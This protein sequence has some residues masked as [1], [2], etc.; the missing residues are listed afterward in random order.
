M[1]TDRLNVLLVVVDSLRYDSANEFASNL[2]ELADENVSFERAIA[3]ASWSLPSHASL[4]T[5]EYPYEHGVCRLHDQMRDVPLVERLRHDGYTAYGVSANGFAGPRMTID[6]SFDEFR[7]TGGDEPFTDGLDV[8][9]L[10]YR[11]VE[12]DVSKLQLAKSLL[13]SSLV[14]ENTPRSIVNLTTA[15]AGRAAANVPQLQRVPH[16]VFTPRKGYSYTPERNTGSIRSFVDEREP[17]FFVF[18]NYM[19][20]HTPYT[21]PQRHLE[22]VTDETVS[23]SERIRLN[24]EVALPWAFVERLEEGTLE[25]AD[26]ERV[27][28]LYEAEV[29]SVDE[30]IG[31]LVELLERRG[32]FEE[33]LVV[34]T[35][36]HGQNLGEEDELGRRRMGHEASASD[37]LLHVPLVVANPHLDDRTIS[38]PVSIRRLYDL[39]LGAADGDVTTESVVES[40]ATDRPVLSQYPALG[41]ES[42]YEAHPDVPKELADQ[43]VVHDTTVAYEDDWKVGVCSD[44]TEWA[45][46]DGVR[47]DCGEA[48]EGLRTACRRAQSEL[49]TASES[50]GSLSE[51]DRSQLE[52]LGYL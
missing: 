39:T 51:Q 24:E 4:F 16:P 43:R 52:A 14:D 42:F 19:D 21:P 49:R 17:P 1:S 28:R 8:Y 40:L 18:A 13:Y 22:R 31:E 35:A 38:D 10:V 34:V 15:L 2:G 11:L 25:E 50:D 30:H 36:D 44:G 3:P 33:T 32:L 46:R 23:R 20:T 47:R 41:G 9:S 7:F 6:Q 27:R 29:S 5:G 26:V 12:E 48:P 37:A 45:V